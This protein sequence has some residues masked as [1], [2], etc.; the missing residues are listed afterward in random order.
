MFVNKYSGKAMTVN[1]GNKKSGT[2]LV[3]KTID[4]S[5]SQKFKPIRIEWEVKGDKYYYYDENGNRS[6]WTKP[7]Y[8]AYKKLNHNKEVQDEKN[9]KPYA[10][11]I[12]VSACWVNIFKKSGDLWAP[13]KCWRCS[14]GAN[15]SNYATPRGVFHTTGKKG[16][17]G[18][19]ENLPWGFYYVTVWYPR[20]YGGTG[21]HSII[22]H[23][24]SYN[25]LD[26]RLGV[27]I[28]GGS[29]RLSFENAKWVYDHFSK[30]TIVYSY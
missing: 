2:P 3:Q 25:V 15:N 23:P 13:Y 17:Y 1:K 20:E 24:N 18:E 10:S 14:T 19:T 16:S 9:S 30:G 27:H 4:N 8:T 21:F 28:T 11:T 7:T 5:A 12:D 22:Y 6:T 26:G 29:V